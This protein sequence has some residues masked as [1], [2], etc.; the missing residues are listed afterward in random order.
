MG[1]TAVLLLL[2]V[3]VASAYTPIG[4]WRG[5]SGHMIDHEEEQRCWR[6]HGRGR[7]TTRGPRYT[8]RGYDHTTRGRR[9]PTIDYEEEA[10]WWREHGRGQTT[11]GPR[12]TTRGYD[13]TTRGRRHPTI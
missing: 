8:T 5:R 1:T 11:S 12:Y 9:P 2:S 10:R 3:T 7:F 13:H 6:D 4:G